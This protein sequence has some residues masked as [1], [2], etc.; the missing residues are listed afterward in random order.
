HTTK[1]LLCI[2]QALEVFHSHKHVLI[3]L[4]VHKHFNI[5][6][7]HSMQHYVAGIKCLGSADGFNMESSEH[8][9]I[10][11]AKCAFKASNHHNY[12]MQMAQWIQCQEAMFINKQFLAWSL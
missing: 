9:H 4:G 8:L 3:D 12:I 10:D 6:K 11:Y 5:L 7:V 1:T 2:E